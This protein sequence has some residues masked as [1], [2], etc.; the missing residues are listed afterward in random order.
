MEIIFNDP[1]YDSENEGKDFTLELKA[2]LA[3]FDSEAGIFGT[4]IGHGADAPAY[5]VQLFTSVDWS[6]LLTASGVG[7]GATFFL[8]KKINENIDAWLEIAGK[9]KKIIDTLSPSRIDEHAATLIALKELEGTIESM[10][11]I[12]IYL[13]LI[14]YSPV[15]WGKYKLDKRPDALYIVT[16]KSNRKAYIYGI[17]SNSNIVFSHEFGLE[18]YE[19]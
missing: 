18:W 2:R 17:K 7:V 4:D 6:T 16:V 8:G 3:P 19:L 9:V 5:L 15:P 13:Q 12:S 1:Y 11:E 14:E 10:A